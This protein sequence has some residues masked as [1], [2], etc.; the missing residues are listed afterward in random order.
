ME[1]WRDV[2]EQLRGSGRAAPAGNTFLAFF[3]GGAAALAVDRWGT[4]FVFVSVS[5]GVAALCL[6]A[7]LRRAEGAGRFT[8]LQVALYSA[9]VFGVSWFTDDLGWPLWRRILTSLA[10]GFVALAVS[11]LFLFAYGR[12]PGGG[13]D[14]PG[15]PSRRA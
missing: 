13:A 9:A 14:G 5:V 2:R 3:G 8:F 6:V 4:G 7:G 12:V 15:Q 10:A 1:R 11:F